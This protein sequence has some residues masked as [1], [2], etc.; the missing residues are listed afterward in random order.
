MFYPNIKAPDSNE[1]N[2][3][4]LDYQFQSDKIKFLKGFLDARKWFGRG[5]EHISALLPYL[6][7][8]THAYQ[9]KMS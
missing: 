6:K 7:V 4:W 8:R 2:T 5:G 9:H 1:P 3:A